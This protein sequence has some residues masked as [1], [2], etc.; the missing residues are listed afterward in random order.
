MLNDNFNLYPMFYGQHYKLAYLSLL[1][2][3]ANACVDR[4]EN[5]LTDPSPLMMEL[6]MDQATIDMELSS[7][8]VGEAA[9]QTSPLTDAESV[10]MEIVLDAIVEDLGTVLVDSGALPDMMELSDIAP[11][12]DMMVSIE[13]G[14]NIDL[15][16]YGA[17]SFHHQQTPTVMG[18]VVRDQN[19]LPTEGVTVLLYDSF[20]T[21]V[22]ET[23]SDV[24]GNFT[25]EADILY[26]F[27]GLKEASIGLSVDGQDCLENKDISFYVCSERLYD[28][29]NAL[30]DT[31]T[32]ARDATWNP[33]G[34]LEMTGIETNRVGA[35]YNDSESILS[36]L[37]SIEFTLITGGGI[38][39][40]ADGFAFTI[41]EL[42]DPNTF[43]TL[44]N[45]AN[46]GGGLGYAVGGAHLEADYTLDGEALTV[47]IDTWYNDASRGARHSDPT[48]QNHLAI[49]RNGDPGDHIAWHEVPTIEDLMPHT[50]RVDFV[51]ESMRIAYDGELVIEQ[52]ITFTFK[53]GYMFFSGSTGAASNYHRFDEVQ[54]LHGCQ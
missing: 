32:L 28:D 54:I 23:I 29:F 16:G 3:A 20:Q 21:P 48:V 46:R 52:D 9:D 13:C 11:P 10:D 47:E 5:N 24:N 15:V 44:I 19:M 25:I 7:I 18:G 38:G 33:Q 45:A 30:A 8:D 27:P 41:V 43:S 12:S 50:V 4:E 34:W 31:W 42:D 14:L 22:F 6:M 53:G 17:Q 2:F 35:V 39:G 36:G 40:G 26:Q 49:T 51:D 37:A 1:V